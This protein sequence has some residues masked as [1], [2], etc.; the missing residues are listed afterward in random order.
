[1]LFLGRRTSG[2][3]GAK[4]RQKHLIPKTFGSG[5]GYFRVAARLHSPGLDV[6]QSQ[7]GGDLNGEVHLVYF[8]FG[9]PV[10]KGI[11]G[12]QEE[13]RRIRDAS[14]GGCPVRST[15][16][17]LALSNHGHTTIPWKGSFYSTACLC[18]EYRIEGYGLFPIV[19]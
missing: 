12:R 4:R 16:F 9:V 18:S 10:W 13:M 14:C 1:V 2:Q 6:V 8:L 3:R 7:P 15:N 11:L 5:T 17:P 19:G